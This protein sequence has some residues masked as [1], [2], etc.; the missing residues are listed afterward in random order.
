MTVTWPPS[1]R[2]QLRGQ[3]RIARPCWVMRYRCSLL[4][5]PACSRTGE[6]RATSGLVQPTFKTRKRNSG[7]VD[8]TPILLPGRVVGSGVKLGADGVGIGHSETWCGL[9]SLGQMPSSRK[10]GYRPA[11]EAPPGSGIGVVASTRPMPVSITRVGLCLRTLAPALASIASMGDPSAACSPSCVSVSEMRMQ[12]R[13][14]ARPNPMSN[15]GI[16][17]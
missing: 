1:R 15:R 12:N 6:P 4:I 9:K 8:R 13:A 14:A 11:R 17:H 3:P 2:S 16:P 7:P 5:P 10:G